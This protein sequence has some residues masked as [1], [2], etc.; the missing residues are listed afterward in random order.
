MSVFSVDRGLSG[1]AV[2]VGEPQPPARREVVVAGDRVLDDRTQAVDALVGRGAVTDEVA[3]ALDAFGAM[4]LD[5][6]QAGFESLEVPVDVRNDRVQR[7]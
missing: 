2:E 4:L 1:V 5:I 7:H 3:Q 6:G